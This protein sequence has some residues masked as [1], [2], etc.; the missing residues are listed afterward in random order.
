MIKT[1]L[2]VTK[3]NGKRR[4]YFPQTE[5]EGLSGMIRF[6]D[7]GHRNNFSLQ[8]VE[9]TVDGHMEQVRIIDYL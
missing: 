9:M 4:Y 6:T 2:P 5:I 3:M 8:V 7:D 1:E